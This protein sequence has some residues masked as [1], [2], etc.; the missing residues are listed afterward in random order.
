[1]EEYTILLGKYERLQ[2][3]ERRLEKA[4]DEIIKLVKTH[5]EELAY[6]CERIINKLSES[7]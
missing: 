3:H 4:I 2:L 6:D 1:M 7:L 5:N